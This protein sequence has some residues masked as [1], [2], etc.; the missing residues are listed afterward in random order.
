MK[1]IKQSELNKMPQISI[2]ELEETK[3]SIRNYYVYIGTDFPI[4]IKHIHIG[5]ASE[6]HYE[7][8]VKLINEPIIKILLD[9]R[10]MY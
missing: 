3:N 1:H 5:L 2:K 4:D 10:K 7:T 6:N 8:I 9:N